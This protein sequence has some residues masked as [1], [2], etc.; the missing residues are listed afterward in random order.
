MNGELSTVNTGENPR[1]G[2]V[3]TPQALAPG[4]ND[5]NPRLKILRLA[6]SGILLAF[7]VLTIAFEFCFWTLPLLLKVVPA[8]SELSN[9]VALSLGIIAVVWAIVLGRSYF[10]DAND[11]DTLSEPER[12]KGLY[13]HYLVGLGFALILVALVCSMVFTGVAWSVGQERMGITAV[14][15]VAEPLM[16]NTWDG[17]E[18]ELAG[19]GGN[20]LTERFGLLFGDSAEDAY[21][22]VGLFALSSGVSILGALFFFVTA[23]WAKMKEPERE[24]FDVSLFWA[25]LWFRLGEAALFNLVFF[26]LL[27]TYAPDRYLV[28]PLVSLLVG[29]FLKAGETLVSGL[30]TRVFAAFEALVPAS[31]EPREQLRLLIFSFPGLL[32]KKE[33][34]DTAKTFTDLAEAIEALPG[35]INVTQNAANFQLGVQYDAV[36]INPARI[37]Q[38]ATL[39]G[40]KVENK[41]NL[42]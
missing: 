42:E 37:K 2:E 29:M 27:R 26:L 35:V 41:P 34:E 11:P 18:A 30:A 5:Q 20:V 21:F 4:Q 23:L 17:K 16:G 14:G 6:A 24:P 25:G 28:L 13:G 33:A 12:S 40:L 36:K 15:H 39:R 7:G 3:G 9:W 10:R 8:M 32:A 22:T 1:S 19:P 38:E 31:M